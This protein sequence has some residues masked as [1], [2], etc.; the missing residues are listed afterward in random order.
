MLITGGV[1]AIL[2]R[3]EGVRSRKLRNCDDRSVAW[4]GHYLLL[5][6]LSLKLSFF[7]SAVISNPSSSVC[8]YSHFHSRNILN[9]TARQWRKCNVN[10]GNFLHFSLFMPLQ[11]IASL[12]TMERRS[13]SWRKFTQHQ[14]AIH[15]MQAQMRSLLS[16]IFGFKTLLF[17]DNL[18]YFFALFHWI[19]FGW[20]LNSRE[21]PTRVS[22]RW[23]CNSHK[24][25]FY[26]TAEITSHPSLFPLNK[27]ATWLMH[28][29]DKAVEWNC[30]QI[31]QFLLSFSVKKLVIFPMSH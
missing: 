29:H 30:M 25:L 4:A 11:C 1:N 26:F 14:R 8:R 3:G 10:N 5:P 27:T 24:V 18:K 7:C 17:E 22:L 21:V 2:R 28:V 12:S 19:V 6:L 9:S 20:A 23:F 31:F 13:N 15:L 16:R